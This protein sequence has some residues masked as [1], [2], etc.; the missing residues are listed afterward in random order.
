MLVEEIIKNIKFLGH[1][2][3]KL[4]VAGKIIFVD[5]WKIKE[6]DKADIILVTHPHFDHYSEEDVQKIT[7]DTTILLSCKEVV[8]QTKVKN[9]KVLLPF[10]E[11]KIE[12]I[13]IQG[14]PAYNVNKHFHPKTNNWLGFVIKYKDIS[15][16]IAGDSDVIEEAKKLKVNIM[17]LPVGGTYTMTDKEAAELVNLTKPDF[18]IPIHY[19]D[20]VGSIQNAQNFKN[21]VNQPT[22]VVLL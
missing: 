9:K 8:Q 2:S 3:V 22:K 4:T 17:L 14:F 5:P 12:D 18:A 16:Y 10:E 19:G 1:S 6:K 15:I 13:S 7:K 21:L 11:E 20:I